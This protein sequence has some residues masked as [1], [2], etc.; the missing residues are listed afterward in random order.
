MK[1]CIECGAELQI[2]KDD[3]CSPCWWSELTGKKYENND[4]KLTLRN[5]ESNIRVKR[6]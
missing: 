1:K 5:Q 6:L 4:Q 2:K 3:Y